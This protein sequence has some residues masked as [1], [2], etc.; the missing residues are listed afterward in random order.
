MKYKVVMVSQI[1]LILQNI[2][3][4]DTISYNSP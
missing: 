1:I 4:F 2:L 3:G